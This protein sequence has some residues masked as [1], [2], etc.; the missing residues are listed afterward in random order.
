MKAAHKMRRALGPRVRTAEQI[1]EMDRA[2]DRKHQFN[3]GKARIY[4][5]E[6][7]KIHYTSDQR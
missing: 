5:E 2:A 1:A 6:R 4:A 7:K 3:L